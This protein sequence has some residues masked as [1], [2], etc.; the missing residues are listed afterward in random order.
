MTAQDQPGYTDTPQLPGQPW[1]VHDA[2]RPRPPAVDPGPAPAPAPVPADAVVLFDGTSLDAFQR[3]G[4]GEARWTLIPADAPRAGAMEVAR[5][6][7]SIETKQ[8]FGDCQLHVEWR[9]PAPPHGDSQGRGN[10]GV[11]LMGRYEVQVLDSYENPTYADGQAA[12]IY[13][14]KP[15]DVNACRPP[16]EW[17]SYDIFFT[18]PRFADGELVSSAYLTVVHNGVLVQ[19]HVALLGSTAHR[20]L[21]SYTPHPPQGPIVL[22][23]HGDPVRFRNIWVRP[24]PAPPAQ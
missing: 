6:G 7:G 15:P 1:R 5:G 13:G 10:S 11:F 9:A 20:T 22:Q 19:N 8:P 24:L 4:G 14:Q 21:P 12:A 16:G 17:Q 23:D 3:Q 18:A 2:E